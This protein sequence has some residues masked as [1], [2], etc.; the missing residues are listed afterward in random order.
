[1]NLEIDLEKQDEADEVDPFGNKLTAASLVCKPA[2]ARLYLDDVLLPD[3]PT[4][5]KLRR[6]GKEHEVRCELPGYLSQKQKTK[7]DGARTEVNLT[8]AVD[9]AAAKAVAAA[10]VVAAGA[11]APAAPQPAAA[12]AAAAPPPEP[13]PAPA[14][15]PTPSTKVK[16]ID[17]SDPWGT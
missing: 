13:A 10:P 14:P 8:L 15:A 5:T 2:T 11:K 12:S 3:N 6:D 16:V 9:P 4:K 1:V 7:L 17:R